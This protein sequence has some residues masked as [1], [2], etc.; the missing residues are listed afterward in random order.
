MCCT[1]VVQVL[2]FIHARDETHLE[3]D[4]SVLSIYPFLSGDN[5]T[6]GQ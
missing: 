1:C 3:P 2:V 5:I 6:S 4:V